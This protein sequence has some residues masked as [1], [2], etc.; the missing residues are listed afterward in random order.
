[1]NCELFTEKLNL[2]FLPRPSLTRQNTSPSDKLDS[3]RDVPDI[4]L[5]GYPAGYKYK[6]RPEMLAGFVEN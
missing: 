3:S 2:L 5:A 1:M 4:R 6:I